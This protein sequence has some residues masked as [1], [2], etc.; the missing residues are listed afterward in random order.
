MPLQTATPFALT[1]CIDSRSW[2]A[3]RLFAPIIDDKGKASVAKIIV[4]ATS[5]GSDPNPVYSVEAIEFEEAPS[6]ATWAAATINA[7]G[8]NPISVRSAE[9]LR[10][11]AKAVADFN[12][13][14][15]PGMNT[16]E[17]KV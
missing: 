2:A 17:S 3:S 5:I 4:K 16:N 7:D 9:G 11:L 13:R 8:I 1:R 10:I 6:A 14:P 12:N 15:D